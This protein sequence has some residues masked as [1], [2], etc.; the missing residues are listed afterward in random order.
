MGA[1]GSKPDV[2]VS[3]GE[4]AFFAER[5]APVQFSEGL[6]NHLSSSSL[7]SSSVPSSRQE[8]LDSH[9]QSRIASELSRLREQEATVREEIER[10]LEKEN[11]DREKGDAE[12]QGVSHSASLMKDLED[13]E[14]RTLGLREESEKE[15]DS[16]AWKSV[17]SQRKALVECFTGNK[18]TP[19]NC[20]AEAGKFKE[21][22]AGVE[23]AFIARI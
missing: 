16:E 2:E 17:E 1:Q 20:Q 12:T 7:P 4:T 18:E 10:A 3:E 23:K 8:T 15:L 13:L 9:I 21:A 19:L 5:A 22:V 6:I 14:K 11:L